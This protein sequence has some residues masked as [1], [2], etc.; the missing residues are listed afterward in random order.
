MSSIKLKIQISGTRDGVE[1]PEPGTV[2][3]VPAEEAAS[4]IAIGAAEEAGTEEIADAPKGDVE[5]A[6]KKRG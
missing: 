6:T 2:I 5:T 1:W 3:D 4:L